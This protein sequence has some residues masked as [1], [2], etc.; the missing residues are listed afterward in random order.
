MPIYPNVHKPRYAVINDYERSKFEK[1]W[2]LPYG[3]SQCLI[4]THDP[5]KA[6][7]LLNILPVGNPQ[8]DINDYIVEKISEEGRELYYRI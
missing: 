8:V 3:Y 4:V 2:Q 5:K 7:N 1:E 6:I